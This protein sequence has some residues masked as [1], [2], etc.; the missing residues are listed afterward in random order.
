M[1]NW[2]LKCAGLLAAVAVTVGSGSSVRAHDRD[3]DDDDDGEYTEYSR[4]SHEVV[5]YQGNPRFRHVDGMRLQ[6][7]VNANI[8]TIRVEA[9]RFFALN[10]GIWFE[11]T[12][13]FGPWVT[14]V[15][16]PA[17]IYEI[18]ATCP[19][20]EV[21]YVRVG[22]GHHRH[23]VSRQKVVVYDPRPAVSVHVGFPV[24][25]AKSSHRWPSRHWDH[26]RSRGHHRGRH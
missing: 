5:T 11:A 1:K 13:A 18:P 9:N 14:A 16:V 21:T 25:V 8:P 17:E 22:G 3:W 2:K 15:S 6:Y 24:V 7:A 26:G 12:S 19:I 4:A 10:A 23:S 20:H